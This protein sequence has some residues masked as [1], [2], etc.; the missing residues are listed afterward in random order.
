[1]PHFV[2]KILFENFLFKKMLTQN[3]NTY[4]YSFSYSY[5][6]LYIFIY[7]ICAKFCTK[8]KRLNTSQEPPPPPTHTNRIFRTHAPEVPFKLRSRSLGMAMD[9]TLLAV[10][11]TSTRFF[12][13]RSWIITVGWGPRI[14][15]LSRRVQKT[16]QCRVCHQNSRFF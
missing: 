7:H 14:F 4:E 2:S 12:R 15:H 3:K 8:K 10:A 5:S 11:A 1:M 16:R 13:R 9:G 6:H